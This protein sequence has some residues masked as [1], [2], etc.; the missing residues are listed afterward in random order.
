[1]ILSLKDNTKYNIQTVEGRRLITAL[2]DPSREYDLPEQLESLKVQDL[3]QSKN[4]I[5]YPGFTRNELN[6]NEYIFHRAGNKL[7]TKNIMGFFS[8]NGTKIKISSRFDYD[9][10]DFFLKYMLLRVANYNFLP[11]N[12]F[13]TR[14]NSVFNLLMCLFPNMLIDALKQGVYKE[15]TTMHHDDLNVR[16]KIDI[17][18]YIKKDMP[19]HGKV[20][21]TTREFS[22]DNKITQLIRHT[23][24]CMKQDEFGN[25]I[26]YNNEDVRKGVNII[27][28][29]TSSYHLQSR[30]KVLLDNIDNI[31]H[32]YFDKYTQLQSLCRQILLNSGIDYG[33]D[34]DSEI[35]GVI[36]DGAWLW[37]EYI[38]TILNDKTFTHP[39][40]TTK[41]GGLQLFEGYLDNFIYPDFYS[42]EKQ[43]VLDAK[44]K[45]L[46]ET[47][48][49][50]IAN[51]QKTKDIPPKDL[52]QIIC[53]MNRL[54]FQKGG[55]VFP[56]STP[57]YNNLSEFK[58]KIQPKYGSKNKYLEIMLFP[59]GIPCDKTDFQS[60][61]AQMKESEKHFSNLVMSTK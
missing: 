38:N 60:F 19:F 12:S 35:H 9:E 52:Y 44:F 61:S 48:F 30:R 32:P 49:Q 36:F 51:G 33:I 18:N 57:L 4:V 24:E 28:S 25:I 6:K 22:T 47:A 59:L 7:N 1:M 17:K 29:A 31:H 21:Y 39:K 10:N 14:Q 2:N 8:L 43:I 26:L 11:K 23:I 27:E 45:P 34:N 54:G 55:F 15:Y 16:G 41:E 56:Y 37:E 3:T 40:N 46:Y 42:C 53:Y 13:N 50:S 58:S 5:S 20:S